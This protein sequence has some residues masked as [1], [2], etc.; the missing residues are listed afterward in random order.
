MNGRGVRRWALAA[1]VF[2]GL[3]LVIPWAAW[4]LV[5]A[6]PIAALIVCVFRNVIG[7]SSF[8]TFPRSEV[9]PCGAQL[10]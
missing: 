1:L 6:K 3:G 7:L 5:P 8:G 9:A 2:V 10:D 4:Y